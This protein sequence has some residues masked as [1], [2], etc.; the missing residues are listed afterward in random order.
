MILY[1]YMI[2][3]FQDEYRWLSNFWPVDIFY[4]GRNF[5]SVEHAYQAQKNVSEAWQ[6]F[7]E[8]EIDPK[9]VK[10]KSG[11]ISLRSDWYNINEKIMEE[12]LYL[13]FSKE[14]FKSQLLHTQGEIQEGNKWGDIFWGVDLESGEGKNRLGKM[15]MKIREE[16]QK[17][18]KC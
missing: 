6:S 10:E 17:N 5:K 2:S 15:I 4:R 3:E 18:E 13:K 12:L 8:K 7:C 11:E 14:P 9:R 16:I 1:L